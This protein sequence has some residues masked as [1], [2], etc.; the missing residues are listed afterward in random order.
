[1]SRTFLPF[2]LVLLAGCPQTDKQNEDSGDTDAEDTGVDVP[3]G[4]ITVDGSGGFGLINDAIASAAE[5][6]VIQLCEGTYEE[7]VVIDKGVTLLGGQG[8][9]LAGPGTDIPLTI[10]GAGVTVEALEITSPRTAVLLDGAIDTTLRDIVTSS[11]GSWAVSASDST[12]TLIEDSVFTEPE[13]GGVQI[14]GGDVTISRCSFDN[15]AGYALFAESGAVVALADS[16][17]DGTRQLAND[18]TDGFAVNIDG[19]TLAMSGNT[20]A[21]I[22]LVG[23]FANAGDSL[24]LDGDTF[25]TIPYGV[26]ASDTPLTVAN[27]TM[28]NLPVVGIYAVHPSEPITIT[29]TTITIAAGTS[30]SDLY[31]DW[32]GFCGG[33]LAASPTVNI[34]GLTVSGYENYGLVV[35]SYDG[36]ENAVVDISNVLLSDLGRWGLRVVTAEGTIDGVT[37][38]GT[39]EPEAD[40]VPCSDVGQAVAMW[41]V[42]ADVTVSNSVVTDNVGWGISSYVGRASVTG[43]T[44]GGNGCAGILNFQ[45]S[46]VIESFTITNSSQYSGIWDYQGV[47]VITGNTFTANHSY[48]LEPYEYYNDGTNSYEYESTQ[49]TSLDLWAYESASMTV[50]G[51]T[52]VDGNRSIYAESSDVEVT[53]NTWTDYDDTIFMNYYDGSSPASFA[54]NV[55]D[56]VGGYV[57]YS[58]ASSVEVEDVEIGTTRAGPTYEVIYYVDGVESYR[59]TSSSSGFP[60]YSYGYEDGQSSLSLSNVSVGNSLYYTLYASDTSLDIDGLTIGT[61]GSTAIVGYW[62]AFPAEL[63]LEGLQIGSASSTAIALSSSNM[64]EGYVALTD[65]VV[66]SAPAGY[67]LSL[68]GLPAVSVTD[69]TFGTIGYDG[70]YSSSTNYGYDETGAYVTFDANTALSLSRVSFASVSGTAVTMSGGSLTADNVTVTAASSS[71]LVLDGLTAVTVSDSSFPS[72]GGYGA[73]VEDTRSYYDYVTA[74]TLTVDADTVSTLTNVSFGP[75]SAEGLSFVGGSVLL[76]GVSATGGAADGLSLDG[77]SYDVQGN[78]FTG[79]SGYGMVCTDAVLTACATNDLTGNTLGT[80]LGC[81]DACGI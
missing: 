75:T 67:G 73:Y 68:I 30:C 45:S 61:A 58:G 1:M 41:L 15:P 28:T 35:G 77:T 20:L 29:D 13:G 10:I 6:A 31:A 3:T 9:I 70:I 17:I 32:E 37:I 33:A 60:F 36:E 57:V 44:F 21:N 11:V 49:D 26:Y 71:G 23:V 46:L 63:E 53:D 59:Y 54:R 7:A 24:S 47:S 14:T 22:E 39:R 65:V 34:S 19:A 62:S 80:H 8:V 78:T 81:D 76:S 12:G 25:D 51:N 42:Y 16:T 48:I 72:A 56:D 2:A 4:C 38:S 74:T 66:D 18:G 79:N 27:V 55:V 69:A 43:S 5:G 52:F 50:S 64:D 40:T